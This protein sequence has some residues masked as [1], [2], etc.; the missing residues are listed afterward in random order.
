MLSQ[1]SNQGVQVT[2]GSPGATH[3]NTGQKWRYNAWGTVKE[4]AGNTSE[5]VEA[6]SVWH[7]VFISQMYLFCGVQCRIF[8]SV[9]LPLLH[10]VSKRRNTFEIRGVINLCTHTQRKKSDLL[11]GEVSAHFRMIALHWMF[12]LH[13]V[14]IR[15]I[16]QMLLKSNSH[17]LLK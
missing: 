13:M 8:Q 7:L 17:C 9:I 3:Q 10:I 6:F 5:R 11:C 15:M 2:K 4:E 12:R 16:T 14:E 1:I